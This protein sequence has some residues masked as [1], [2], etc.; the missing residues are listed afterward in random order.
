MIGDILALS[1]YEKGLGM[2]IDIDTQIP[3]RLVG[4]QMQLRG[5]LLNLS[6]NA[7]KFTNTG[8]IVIYARLE[9]IDEGNSRAKIIFQV[10]DTGIGRFKGVSLPNRRYFS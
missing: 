2:V 5:I 10:T 1:A 6:T 3:R 8:H 4:D 9:G 7:I